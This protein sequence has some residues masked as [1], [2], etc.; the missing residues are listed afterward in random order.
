MKCPRC[1]EGTLIQIKFKASG[2]HARL[3]SYCEALWFDHEMIAK[4]TGH[5]L[6]VY[7]QGK[8]H[9]FDELDDQD[10]DGIFCQCK[11]LK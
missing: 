9:E 2:M 11:V 6:R 4:T 5:T 7:S 1:D 3:C 8:E 10:Q